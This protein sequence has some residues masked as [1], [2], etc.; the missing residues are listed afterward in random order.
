MSLLEIIEIST[1]TKNTFI[2]QR[3]IGFWSVG[4]S[5]FP[6]RY[7]VNEEGGQEDQAKPI[8]EEWRSVAK[9][10]GVSGLLF[11][12]L[13]KYFEFPVFSKT[14]KS[15]IQKSPLLLPQDPCLSR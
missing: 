3:M 7:L 2:R 13:L 5:P 12:F 6:F 10:G 11:L 14:Q 1:F 4:C 9:C 8:S 15:N